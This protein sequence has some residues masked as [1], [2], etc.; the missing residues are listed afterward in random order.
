MTPAAAL[1]QR[2]PLLL[3]ADGAV[4]SPC[5]SICRMEADG[6]CA[7]CLRTLPEIAGWSRLDDGARRVVWG[8]ILERA[9]QLERPPP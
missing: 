8:T 3:A 5:V 7:G 9:R 6:L 1:L 4:G 2:G